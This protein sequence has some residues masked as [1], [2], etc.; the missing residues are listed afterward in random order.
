MLQAWVDVGDVR[1]LP[2]AARGECEKR[3]TTWFPSLSGDK[4]PAV[5]LL[6]LAVEL[7]VAAWQRRGI[8][9]V[10]HA[11]EAGVDLIAFEF[12]EEALARACLAEAAAALTAALGEG[13]YDPAVAIRRL[14]E[15][16]NRI[17]IG[18]STNE[19]AQ[20]ARRRGIPVRRLDDGSLMQLGHGAKQRRFRMAVTDGTRAIAQD[21][22]QDK[23]I[24]KSLLRSV[25]LPVPAG[26]LVT[27]AADAWAA[28]H[29]IGLPVVVKPRNANHGRG[30][31]MNLVTL[32]QIERAYEVAVPEGDGVLVE[33]F[34]VGAEHRLL[35]V[36]GKMIAASRGEPELVVGDGYSTVRALV[37]QLNADP[38]RGDDWAAPLCTIELDA[39]AGIM[40]A[41]QGYTVDSVPPSGKTVLI[42]QNGEFLTDVTDDVHPETVAIVVLA[43]RVIG[44]DVA[45]IDVIVRDIRRP[46]REQGLKIIEVNAGPGLR[47]H[48]EP[49]FGKPRPVGEAIVATMFAPGDDGRIPIIAVVGRGATDVT[50]S[51]HA[52]L[53]PRFRNI[54][55][56]DARGLLVGEYVLSDRPSADA[57]SARLLFLHPDTEAAVLELS[58]DSIAHEGLAFD[59]CTAAVVLDDVNNPFH[60]VVIDAALRGHGS[61]ILPAGDPHA[62]KLAAA[63]P[64][65]VTLVADADQAVAAASSLRTI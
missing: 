4:N 63:Q 35:V 1:S 3:L 21:I 59:A 37:D 11:D 8:H 44:L 38:L 64:D 57:A 65:R 30:V 58:A 16:A 24:T 19:I 39:V 2:A 54:G 61:V 23:D 46:P 45:G 56:T 13:L 22:A 62:A 5:L 9:E 50:R 20:A 60:R 47:M 26:R 32:D 41:Q 48:F 14:R 29:E 25:G 43:A 17:C 31:T 55:L 34:A 33:T 28:A 51:L 42:H 12:V 52:L 36:D 27:S 40:L 53:R 6:N 15:L 7:H 10:R 18:P 49:Q